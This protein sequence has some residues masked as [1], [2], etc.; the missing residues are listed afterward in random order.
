MELVRRLTRLKF[1]SAVYL[2]NTFIMGI[3]VM[4]YTIGIS[5]LSLARSSAPTEC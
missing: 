4:N 5:I 3:V 1:V 2:T